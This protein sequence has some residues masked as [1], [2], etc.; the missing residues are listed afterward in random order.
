LFFTSFWILAAGIVGLITSALFAGK[1]KLRRHVFLVPYVTISSLFLLGFFYW[2][3]ISLFDLIIENWIYGLSGGLVVGSLLAKNVFSQ[4]SSEETI[5]R[6]WIF[7]ISWLGIVYGV[8]DALLLN[9]MPIIVVWNGFDQIGLLSTWSWQIIAGLLGLGASL[10][11]TLLYHIGYPEFRNKNVGLVLIGNT[12]ISLAY[13]I[14]T[15]PLGAIL[16]HTMMHI[17]A[18]VKGPET[19]IQLP[20]HYF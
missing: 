7:D 4:S 13:L 9:V 20:P 10:L 15:N 5:E 11:V 6:N 18:V 1:M 2:N 16:S 3:S 17:A 14:S 12:I 8:I 19:T